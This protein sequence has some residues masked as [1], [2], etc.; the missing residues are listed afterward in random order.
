MEWMALYDT[1]GDGVGW[2]GMHCG[3]AVSALLLCKSYPGFSDR[4][5][6]YQQP[7]GTYLASS[8]TLT[9]GF[10]PTLVYT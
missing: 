6:F 5:A 2:N 8:L 10:G 3:S 4:L 7:N 1:D 9:G